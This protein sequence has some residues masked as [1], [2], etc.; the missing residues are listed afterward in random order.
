VV[1]DPISKGWVDF[2]VVDLHDNVLL[3]A[4]R[5]STPMDKRVRLITQR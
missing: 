3:K 1:Q 4:Q 5:T 2:E